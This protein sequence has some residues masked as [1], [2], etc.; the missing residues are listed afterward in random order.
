MCVVYINSA[1]LVIRTR[2]HYIFIKS[3]SFNLY[4]CIEKKVYNVHLVVMTY[5]QRFG[6]MECFFFQLSLYMCKL[7]EYFSSYLVSFLTKKNV[8]IE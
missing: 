8:V 4:V 6:F 2:T 7:F 3:A 1:D 5:F